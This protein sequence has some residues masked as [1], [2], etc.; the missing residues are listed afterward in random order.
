MKTNPNRPVLRI[1]LTK[2]EW[3]ME[4]IALIGV[5]CAVALAAFHWPALPERLPHHF[6]AAGKPDAWG[7]KES[8]LALPAVALLLY[9]VLSVLSRFPHRYNYLW[10]I[11]PENARAQYLL[12]RQLLAAIKAVEVWTFAWILWGTIRTALGSAGGLGAAFLPLSL[13]AVFGA[14]AVYFVRSYQLR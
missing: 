11:T 9:A 10:P 8:M 13:A 3:G 7:S 6:N 14:L 1:P 2:I 4:A 12:A 5:V